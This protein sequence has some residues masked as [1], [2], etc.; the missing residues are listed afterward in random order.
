MSFMIY[1]R[2]RKIRKEGTA[3]GNEWKANKVQK[4]TLR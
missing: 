3:N 4:G 2:I 1:N